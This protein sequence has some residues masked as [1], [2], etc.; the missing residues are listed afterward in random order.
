M[1]PIILQLN[2]VHVNKVGKFYCRTVWLTPWCCQ[3]F[4]VIININKDV[5][6]L[7]A[8]ALMN[9]EIF[10]YSHK[11]GRAGVRNRQW[12]LT[13]HDFWKAPKLIFFFSSSWLPE[14]VYCSVCVCRCWESELNSSVDINCGKE[15]WT[16][17]LISC[18]KH[19]TQVSSNVNY[20][21]LKL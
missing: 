20:I 17:C 10:T 11:T 6:K 2:L 8:F 7:P 13:W 5:K 3:F 16:N 18:L 15:S 14:S 21:Y 12:V 19:C 4:R 1:N 9:T